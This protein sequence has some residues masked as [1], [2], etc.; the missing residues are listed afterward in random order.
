MTSRWMSIYFVLAIA[1]G[2]AGCGRPEEVIARPEQVLDFPSLYATNCAGCHGVDGGHGAAQPLNDPL[3]LAIVS[4][5]RLRDVIAHGVNATPMAAFD[6]SSGGMLTA[7]QVDVLVAGL[8]KT[9]GS[10]PEPGQLPAYGET[11]SMARGWSRGDVT[12]GANVFRTYCLRCHTDDA[13]ARS[14][15]SVIDESFL[16]LTSDQALRTAV[17]T[18]RPDEGAPS[19]REC[20]SGQAMSEQDISDVV[21]WMASHRGN[22]E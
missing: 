17:I 19:W 9:W 6:R 13:R 7:E 3:Y 18:G 4:D 11:E 10:S 14:A 15:G 12:R 5:V 21:A 1:A 8:R 20:Q 16:A 22:H 2:A